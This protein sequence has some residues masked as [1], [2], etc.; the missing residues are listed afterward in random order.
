[1]LFF[2]E[3]DI[4]M[5]NNKKVQNYLEKLYEN[6]KEENKEKIED[7]EVECVDV[8]KEDMGG[9]GEVEKEGVGD[10]AKTAFQMAAPL[11]GAALGTATGIGAAPGMIAGAVGG[12]AIM[13]ALQKRKE[14]KARQA[15]AQQG[16]QN[17]DQKYAEIAKQ[18]AAASGA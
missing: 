10:L 2:L 5:R 6:E 8:K 1:L 4:T 11:G 17:T 3:G 12:Q 16:A 18:K 9:F 7:V 15:A 13:Q 14:A